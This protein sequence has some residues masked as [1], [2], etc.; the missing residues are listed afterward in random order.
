MRS[1]VLAENAFAVLKGASPVEYLLEHRSK[2][3]EECEVHRRGKLIGEY[4]FDL[5]RK[6]CE[7]VRDFIARFEALELRA[8]PAVSDQALP[9]EFRT[10]LFM[11]KLGLPPDRESQIISSSVNVSDTKALRMRRWLLFNEYQ[12]YEEARQYKRGNC[13]LKPALLPLPFP[14]QPIFKNDGGRSFWAFWGF[15][16]HCVGDVEIS[17]L[18]NYVF[19]LMK[20]Q[21]TQARSSSVHVCVSAAHSGIICDNLRFP[22]KKLVYQ[23]SALFVFIFGGHCSTL[24]RRIGGAR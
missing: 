10:H 16:G 12:Y 6:P 13:P 8:R 21:R 7:L 20:A 4:L 15:A 2:K 14:P 5:Q 1:E 11:K 23:C 22:P 17:P 9:D 19:Y 24:L 3:Y 18:K